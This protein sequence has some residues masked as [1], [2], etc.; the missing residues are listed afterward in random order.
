MAPEPQH[1][2]GVYARI[3]DGNHILLVHKTRGPYTGLLDLPGGSP[4]PG[5]SWPQTLE[6]ELHEE[7]G[8]RLTPSGDFQPFA[9]HV[10]RASDGSPIDFHHRGVFLDLQLPYAPT[11]VTSPDTAGSQWFD[12]AGDH[13]RLSA[14]VR[15]VI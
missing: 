3:R 8:I 11:A 6:R 5:E 1:H 2:F 15:V 14:V 7:L 12:L 4:E 13:A 10:R 9:V